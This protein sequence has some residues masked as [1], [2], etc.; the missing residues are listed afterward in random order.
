[1][2]ITNAVIVERLDNMHK[3]NVVDHQIM[4]DGIDH[5]NGDVSDLKLEAAKRAGQ[6]QV[7]GLVLGSVVIPLVL[8]FLKTRLFD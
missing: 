5:T 1:M 8:Y 2:K 3:H 7:I 4:K 6:I